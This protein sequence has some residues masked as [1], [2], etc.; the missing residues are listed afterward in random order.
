MDGWPFTRRPLPVADDNMVEAALFHA[1]LGI[2]GCIGY[3]GWLGVTAGAMAITTAIIAIVL[4][5]M[6]ERGVGIFRENYRLL[7]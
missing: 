7:A 6:G 3:M 1:F 4:H 2:F 5:F